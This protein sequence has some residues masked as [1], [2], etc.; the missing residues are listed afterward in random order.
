MGQLARYAHL[1]KGIPR[2]C[3]LGLATRDNTTLTARDVRHAIDRGVN[4]LNWCT[5]AD[6]LSRAIAEL[7][8]RRDRVV[9]AV[10]FYAHSAGEARRELDGYLRELR[11]DYVDIV[12]FYYL[13]HRSEWRRITG[14][15]GA[16]ETLHRARDVGQVRLI[17]VTSHQ[18]RLAA[19][20]AGSGAIDLL[21]IRYNAAHRGAEHDIFPY[22]Q[23]GFPVVAY[24]CLRWGALIRPTPKDPPDATVPTSHDCYR[25]V[26]THPSVSVAVMAPNGRRELDADLALLDEWRR[27]RRD[28]MA[29]VCAH[30]ERVSRTAGSFP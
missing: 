8:H 16:M 14:R 19:E 18:R 22:L 21:M 2:V 26:M 13:E 9:V 3:R 29:A 27:L 6:G 24:T 30:G 17:G 10:Q 11:T 12:T 5:H 25:F 7:K 20:I 23:K 15:D 4:Y 1:G 28:E